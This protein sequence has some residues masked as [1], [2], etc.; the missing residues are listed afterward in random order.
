MSPHGSRIV[1]TGASSGIGRALAL[2]LAAPGRTLWLVARRGTLLEEVAARAREAGADARPVELDVADSAAAAGFLAGELDGGRVVD[3]AYLAAAVSVFGEVRDLRVE[4]W[5]AVYR[6]DLLG[7]VQ[8]VHALYAG[9]VPR[10]GG[11]I[12]IVGSV[13]G[14][15]GFPTSVPYAAMK[16][17]LL[18]LCRSLWAEARRHG[19]QVQ[20]A[21][22][23]F[24]DTPIYRDAIYRGSTYEQNMRRIAAL[25]FGMISAED[26]AARILRQA[27]RG[28][29]RFAF[30]WYAALLAALAPRL[31]WALRSLHRKLVE[32]FRNPPLA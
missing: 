26:A 14:C 32:G 23:G 17:G 11:R 16:A 31:P 21:L 20:L 2:Q 30:P 12:V 8:W 9:M 1:I 5:Q 4:D 15:A 3:E 10:R 18:G 19:V 25:G 22:P 7:C 27:G 6:I 29:R 13:A 28:R 24:V